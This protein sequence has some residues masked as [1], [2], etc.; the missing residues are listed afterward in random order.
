MSLKFLAVATLVLA[1]VLAAIPNLIW[2]LVYSLGRLLDFRVRYAPFGWIAF[3]LAVFCVL[4]MAYGCFVGR[5]MFR[6]TEFEYTNSDIPEAF[7]GYRIIHISDLHL[8]T[9]D[10]NRKQLEKI[11]RQ[12]N[13]LDAD[14]VCFTGDLV[15]VGTKEAEP[16]TGQLKAIK[17]R[18]G[19]ISVL[20]NHDFMIYAFNGRSERDREASVDS[21]ANYERETLGWKLLRN[22]NLS[23]DREGG[24][25][26]FVGVDNGNCSDQGFR[27]INKSDLP[28]AME[29]TDG[30]RILLS[31][32][33]SQWEAE[34]VGKVDIPLT[35]S[36]HTHAAQVRLFGWTPASWVFRQ[37]DGR[38]DCD[39]QTLYVNI[40]LG[41]TAPVRIGA[42]PEITVI[43]LN[44]F[45]TDSN[46]LNR[47]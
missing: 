11:V 26:T 27:T 40:G 31:H 16:Y 38:Y 17:S 19:V 5:W 1:L 24:K 32:D 8:S 7:D 34:V 43:T 30:F 12:I 25:I 10:D 35:L 15:T 18:D 21:L 36:G 42:R 44:H 39:G 41:C 33:P 3:G 6:V 47:W 20:G 46:F 14:L 22:E 9:F 13:E 23:I 45:K 37:T 4:T 29:G 2:L 28:K